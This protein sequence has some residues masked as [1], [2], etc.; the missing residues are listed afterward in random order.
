MT[1]SVIECPWE[2]G[3]KFACS[4]GTA[5]FPNNAAAA[6][7]IL[8][9]LWEDHAVIDVF[10]VVQLQVVSVRMFRVTGRGATLRITPAALVAE[11]R[12][13]VI[14]NNDTLGSIVLLTY[15]MDKVVRVEWP[16]SKPF[17]DA[18][19]P[20]EEGKF[21]QIMY[22]AALNVDGNYKLIEVLDDQ[23]W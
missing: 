19:G 13:K 12:Y 16:E 9:E 22:V 5:I 8:D 17:H 20:I 6:A 2:I 7:N 11:N 15:G 21:R 14:R 4:V 23:D 1:K 10:P 3:Y 18:F